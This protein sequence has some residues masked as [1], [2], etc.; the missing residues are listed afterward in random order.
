MIIITKFSAYTREG[1]RG[2][3]SFPVAEV[4]KPRGFKKFKLPSNFGGGAMLDFLAGKKLPGIVALETRMSF[5]KK[6]EM[7]K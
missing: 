4:L 3:G 1:G 7:L 5:A 2:N 6:R